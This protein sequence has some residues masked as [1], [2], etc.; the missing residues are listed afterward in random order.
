M[1]KT[2]LKKLGGFCLSF[3]MELF[4]LAQR[5][6]PDMTVFIPVYTDFTLGHKELA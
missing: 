4:H 1:I 2:Y 6:I 3:C 5:N